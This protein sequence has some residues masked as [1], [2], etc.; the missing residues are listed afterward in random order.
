MDI[1]DALIYWNDWW[2]NKAVYTGI[3]RDDYISKIEQILDTR[4]IIILEGV[5]RSGKTTLMHQTINILLSK[6]DKVNICYINLDDDRFGEDLRQIYESYLELVSPSGKIYFFIDEVQNIPRWEKWIKSVYDKDRNIKFII[7]GSTS[8]LL[9]REFSTLLSGR[10]FKKHVMPLSFKEMLTFMKIGNSTEIESIKNKVLYRK[11]FSEFIEYGGFPEA[12]LESNIKIK[13]ERLRTY[14][15]SI[16][17]K[18]IILKN[19][20]RRPAKVEDLIYYLLSNI[21]SQYNYKKLANALDISILTADSY[22]SFIRESFLLD[23]V[24]FFSYKVKEQLQYPRKIYCI[25]TGLRN[26]VCF[27]FR[28]NLGQLYE[29][30]VF[31]ELKRRD[32][33]VYYWKNKMHQECDFIIKEGLRITE[34]IQVCYNLDNPET[35]DREIKGILSAMKEFRL[36]SGLIITENYEGEETF[37]GRVIR[38]VPLWKWLLW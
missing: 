26:A 36:D 37:K 11:T 25:D 29:N 13:S 21:A 33:E 24:S 16:V 8:T 4:E 22:L 14:F 10:Y 27:K 38:F 34:L 12:V 35:K 2:H 3:P 32:R 1:K 5:R 18:D 6:T 19:K 17:L 28:E 23:S 7:S 31:T 20:V 15:E 9:S 30:V